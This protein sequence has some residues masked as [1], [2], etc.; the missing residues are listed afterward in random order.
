[1]KTKSLS[2]APFLPLKKGRCSIENWILKI[3]HGFTLIEMIVVTAVMGVV[4]VGATWILLNT[5]KVKTITNYSEKVEGNGS[6]IIGEIRKNLLNADSKTVDCSL[7]NTVVFEDQQ[8][9]QT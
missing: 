2:A 3:N 6:F 1:M 7:G 8:G 4:I 9:N 5:L